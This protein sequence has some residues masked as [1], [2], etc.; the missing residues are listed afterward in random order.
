MVPIL[1]ITYSF[2]VMQRFP[3]GKYLGKL[4][5]ISFPFI[6]WMTM[7]L[8]QDGAAQIKSFW[9]LIKML[10]IIDCKEEIN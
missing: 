7:R 3:N 9:S 10:F 8:S 2:I 1:T 4:F 6:L 5:A